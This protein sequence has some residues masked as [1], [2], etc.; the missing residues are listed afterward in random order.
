[1]KG[2]LKTKLDILITT[3]RTLKVTGILTLLSWGII[4][5]V[6]FNIK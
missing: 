3:G 4:I 1:M 2:I 6:S 5:F